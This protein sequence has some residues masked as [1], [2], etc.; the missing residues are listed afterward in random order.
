MVWRISPE[1]VSNEVELIW[2][3]NNLDDVAIRLD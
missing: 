3:D 1:C 2:G